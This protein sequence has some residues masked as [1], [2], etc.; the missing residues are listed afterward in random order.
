MSDVLRLDQKWMERIDLMIGDA[1]AAKSAIERGGT[2]VALYKL[3][4]VSR[5][6][7]E[8]SVELNER[9]RPAPAGGNHV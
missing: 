3:N 6:A 5:I 4:E 7:E 9:L 8:I 1:E 2:F